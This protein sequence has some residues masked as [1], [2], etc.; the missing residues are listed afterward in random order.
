M[1]R[2]DRVVPFDHPFFQNDRSLWRSQS[3]NTWDSDPWADFG[4]RFGSSHGIPSLRQSDHGFGAPSRFSDQALGAPSRLLD[5]NFGMGLAEDDLLAPVPFRGWYVRPRRLGAMASMAATPQQT[6]T[7]M[8]G[9]ARQ[10]SSDLSEL[11][12]ARQ[13]SSGLSEVVNNASEFRVNLDVAQFKPGEVVVKTVDNKITVHGLHEERQDEHGF[14]QREFKRSYLLPKDVDGQ[15]VKCSLSADGILQVSATKKQISEG[16]E[17]NIPIT[18]E[19]TAM[20]SVTA[21]NP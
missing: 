12:L 7:G 18:M 5:Q 14:I 20:P 1:S 15:D 17:R 19:T 8:P 11:S 9:F 4:S 3:C 16:P 21:A 2:S 6:L 13:M 10:L